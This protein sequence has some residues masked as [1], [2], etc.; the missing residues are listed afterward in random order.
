MKV[1]LRPNF[2]VAQVDK[3]EV[4]GF[5]LNVIVAGALIPCLVALYSSKSLNVAGHLPFLTVVALGASALALITGVRLLCQKP[6]PIW[7]VCC[8]LLISVTSQL[9][10]GQNVLAC[11]GVIPLLHSMVYIWS[12]ED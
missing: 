10:I 4:R 11:F 5:G 3:A 12:G 7:L 9:A 6:T 1:A 8:V 2:N